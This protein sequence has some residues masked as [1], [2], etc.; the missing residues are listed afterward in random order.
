MAASVSLERSWNWIDDSHNQA[1][2]QEQE[3]E[4]GQEQGQE[5]TAGAGISIL[6]LLPAPAAD[7]PAPAPDWGSCL[8]R[9]GARRSARRKPGF[10]TDGE[11]L[12]CR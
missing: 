11:R 12:F 7:F 2:E 10:S 1:Q 4:Q 5:Q 6:L 9:T 8:Q 3:Q